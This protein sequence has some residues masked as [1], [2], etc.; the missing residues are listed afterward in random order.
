MQNETQTKTQPDKAQRLSLSHRHQSTCHQNRVVSGNHSA[1]V[2]ELHGGNGFIAI[3]RQ[4]TG[5]VDRHGLCGVRMLNIIQNRTAEWSRNS[6]MC[7]VD[8][9]QLETVSASTV[10]VALLFPDRYLISKS[11]LARAFTHRCS[12]AG[13]LFCVIT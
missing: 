6:C 1:G 8:A 5:H 4:C 13:N 9:M 7:S 10:T 3:A 2:V 11:K 12:K